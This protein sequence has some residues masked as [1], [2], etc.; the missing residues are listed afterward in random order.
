VRQALEETD[1]DMADITPLRP[2]PDEVAII[3]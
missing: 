1:G 3:A 2:V